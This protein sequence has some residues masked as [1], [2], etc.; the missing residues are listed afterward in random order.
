MEL[1]HLRY[2]VAVAEELSFTRA[3]QRLH[4][5]QPPLSIQIRAL[6]DELKVQLF[7]RD[8]RRVFLT[9]AGKHFLERARGI[10]R[11]VEE[12][13]GEAQNAAAGGVARLALGYTASSMLSAALPA[14]LQRLRR[15]HPQLSLDL[16]EMPSLDQLDAVNARVLDLG[17]LRRPDVPLPNGLVVEPWYR[18]PLV[19]VLPQ[20]HPLARAAVRIAHLRDEPLVSYPRDAGIGLYWK[21]QE[22]CARAGFRPRMVQEARDASTLV[23]LVAAGVGIAVMPE[24]TRCIQLPGVAYQRLLDKDAVSTLHLA[25]RKAHE[26]AFLRVVVERLRTAPPAAR[27]TSASAPG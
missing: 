8:K 9:Q 2:F 7:E 14:A 1:R 23:G 24:D 6:E 16:H 22:L 3:A 19:A 10:L 15:D 11:S 5:A 21:V 4:I 18:A 27:R 25:Y 13:K 17:I 20:R 26:S 12:A